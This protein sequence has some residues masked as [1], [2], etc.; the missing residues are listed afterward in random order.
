MVVLKVPEGSKN[1]R[2]IQFR[3]GNEEYIPPETYDTTMK[4]G[5]IL[6]LPNIIFYIVKKC[7]KK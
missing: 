1:L 2:T 3:Y 7:Q 5:F 6:A 4:L